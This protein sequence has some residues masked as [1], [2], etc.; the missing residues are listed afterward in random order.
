MKPMSPEI[1]E[2]FDVRILDSL[3]LVI[4]IVPL[5][6]PWSV[7]ADKYDIRPSRQ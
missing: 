2:E 4:A 6:A 1:V 7:T 3:D 5:R